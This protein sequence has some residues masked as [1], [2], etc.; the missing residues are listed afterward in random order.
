[1]T[2]RNSLESIWFGSAACLP[3][4]RTFAFRSN[5]VARFSRTSG[6]RWLLD[7]GIVRP[8]QLKPGEAGVRAFTRFCALLHQ[9][10]AKD[11]NAGS[12]FSA[13]VTLQNEE[14]L[15]QIGPAASAILWTTQALFLQTL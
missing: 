5:P 15:R 4:I 11:W 9:I 13:S 3:V 10:A 14:L 2:F 8:L 12:G 6:D 1:M 7:S